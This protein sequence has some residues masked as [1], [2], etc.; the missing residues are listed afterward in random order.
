M[1][2][3]ALPIP[4]FRYPGSIRPCIAVSSCLAGD[5]VRYDGAL[6]SMPLYNYLARSLDIQRCCPEVEAGMST[7]RPAIQLVSTEAGIITQGRD[8]S[9]LNPTERLKA[10]AQNSLKRLLAAPICGYLF[11]S[12]SPSCGVD[13][14]PV[15]N[16]RG[17][18]IGLGS[19]V[20][21]TYFQQHAPWLLFK[22]ET[23]LS[24]T[25]ACEQFILQCLYL[26]NYLHASQSGHQPALLDHYHQYGVLLTQDPVQAKQQILEQ[27]CP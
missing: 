9:S 25:Q 5:R 18:T 10:T 3:L 6:K 16:T 27:L 22:Q 1:S 13:S 21:A 4:L 7:P 11:K 26:S 8:D 15:H 12:R 24:S 14:T 20:Q 23:D 2:L 19:G 17:Q